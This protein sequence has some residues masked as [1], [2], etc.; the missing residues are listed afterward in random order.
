MTPALMS[1]EERPRTR[2]CSS[3]DRLPSDVRIQLDTMLMD[4]TNSFTDLAQWLK[5]QGHEISRSAIGRY[6]CRMNKVAQ[7]L[8]ETLQ[9]TQLVAN[10]VAAN[11]DLDYTKAASLVLMDGLMR[12]VATADEEFLEMPLDKAGRLIGTMARNATYEQRVR[13][14]M[15]KKAELAFEQLRTELMDAIKQHPELV[16]ELDSVLTRALEKVVSDGN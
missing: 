7:R 12:R 13:Q 4:N 16:A 8:A 9:R 10:A 2:V 14:D 5:E 1:S 11:P 6:S 3:I 15:K